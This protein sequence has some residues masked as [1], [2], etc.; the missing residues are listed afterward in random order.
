MECITMFDEEINKLHF[1]NKLDEISNE[2]Y[3]NVKPY[4]HCMLDNILD[5]DF[6]EKCQQEILTIPCEMWDRYNNLFEQKNTLRDKNSM[7][8]YCDALFKL[9]T[10]DKVI[11]KLSN[12]VGEQ[13]YNDPT[14]NWWG[15]HT[16]NNSDYLDIHSDAG[17]HPITKQKK[18]ITFGIYLSYNW[19]EEN[20]GQI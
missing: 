8:R 13:L 10:S 9:L 6:A 7:P 2:E 12:I 4:P 3:N 16:Y 18:H 1:L 14:K 15:I 19:S 5:T 17:N 11:N 20:G